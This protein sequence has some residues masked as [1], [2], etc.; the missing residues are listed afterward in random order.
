MGFDHNCFVGRS[1]FMLELRKTSSA[2]LAMQPRVVEARERQSVLVASVEQRLKW[3]A[4]ANPAL[5]EVMAAF[6]TAV[7][8]RA[9]R[10]N[11]DQSLAAVVGNT[12]TTVLHHEALRT[13]TSEALAHDTAFLQVLPYIMSS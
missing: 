3:A 4:G 1:S 7:A 8:V 2:L 13:R 11:L 12:C 6:E 9:E 5:S 10:L